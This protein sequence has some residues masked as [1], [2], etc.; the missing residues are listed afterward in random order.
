MIQKLG[1]KHVQNLKD[2]YSLNNVVKKLISLKQN[3]LSANFKD[4]NAEYFKTLN[5][6][7]VIQSDDEIPKDMQLLLFHVLEKDVYYYHIHGER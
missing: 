7:I 3:T 5:D 4:N 2:D 6:K 1:I